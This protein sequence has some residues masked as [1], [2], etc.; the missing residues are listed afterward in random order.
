MPLAQLQD[1]ALLK[2][3]AFIN[4]QWRSG[5]GR[6]AVTDPATGRH[7]ADVADVS[8]GQVREAIAAAEAALRDRK[9]VV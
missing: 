3:D 2:T 9:S 8:A 5:E 1:P 6:F 7:L 4:G